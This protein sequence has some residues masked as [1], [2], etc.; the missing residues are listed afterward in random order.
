MDNQ[1]NIKD[2]KVH[3]TLEGTVFEI[4]F[5]IVAIVVW[6]I[7]IWLVHRAPDIVPTHFDASGN[8][9]AYGSPVGITI[10]CIILTIAAISLIVLAYFPRHINMP[11]NITNICQVEMT[12]RSTRVAAIT[13]LVLCLAIVYTLLGMDSPNPI[14]IL[15]VVGIL[16]LEI[17]V[18]S[19]LIKKAK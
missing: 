15:T 10:P 4:V 1:F 17:I 18:F 6:G 8:P 3:R 16:L 13:L 9:N 19:L 11:V 7:I 5:A 2:V 12:I 14:P